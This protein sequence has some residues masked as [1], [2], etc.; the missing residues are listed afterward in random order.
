M[1]DAG[2]FHFCQ[3]NPVEGSSMFQFLIPVWSKPKVH[4]S[5]R[6]FPNFCGLFKGFNWVF[7]RAPGLSPTHSHFIAMGVEDHLLLLDD[8]GHAWAMGDPWAGGVSWPG[9][10]VLEECILT[11]QVL[12]ILSPC[13]SFIQV[14]FGPVSKARDQPTVLLNVFKP[15]LG[16]ALFLCHQPPSMVTQGSPACALGGLACAGK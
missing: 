6:M 9:R 3:R 7:T 2:G 16:L 14:S 8:A 12:Q 10:L 4:T 1:D 11:P 5:L 13:W 15:R